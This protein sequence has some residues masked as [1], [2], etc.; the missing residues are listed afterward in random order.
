M[1]LSFR[2]YNCCV[3]SLGLPR[4]KDDWSWSGPWN[5]HPSLQGSSERWWD[6]HKQHSLYFCLDSWTCTQV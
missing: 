6:Q 5:C 2:F 4:W 1:I 3:F